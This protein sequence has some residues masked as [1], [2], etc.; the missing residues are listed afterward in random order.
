MLMIRRSITFRRAAVSAPALGLA[1]ALLVAAGCGTEGEI[2]LAQ[3]PDD[4][5]EKVEKGQAR[6]VARSDRLPPVNQQSR[7]QP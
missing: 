1:A 4:A 2:E 5:T 6:P 3:V 7:G